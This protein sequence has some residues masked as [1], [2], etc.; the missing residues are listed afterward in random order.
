VLNLSVTD[1]WWDE[2]YDGTN[3]WAIKP[4][5][6]YYDDARRN[7]EDS[8]TLYELLQDQ[9]I[10]M[11][12]RRGSLGFSPEWV[13][14]A[15][16]SIA[17][18]LP[19]FNSNRM[20]REYMDKFY[21]PASRQWHRY[22]TKDFAAARSL[23]DWK[24]RVQQAWSGVTIRRLDE[25]AKRIMYSE[26]VQVQVAVDLNGLKPAD[27][28]VEMLVGRASKPGQEHELRLM[29]FSPTGKDGKENVFT[30][31]MTPEYCGRLIYRIRVFPHNDLL[32]HPFELGLMLW[33]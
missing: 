7:R 8:Q 13:H 30:L 23:A 19:Q 32:T 18:L 4:A 24:A 25:P 1:G 6:E 11:Y 26:N 20:V 21:G 28:R 15:K 14:M 2:G 12:Y 9:V 3:G 33:L 31:E 27:V 5:P 29:S 16:R 22:R 10:P 17:T